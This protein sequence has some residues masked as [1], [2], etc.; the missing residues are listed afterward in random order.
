MGSEVRESL[1]AACQKFMEPIARFLIKHGIGYKEFADVAKIAFV[2]V[3][4]EEYGKRGRPTNISRTSV[5]TGL[6]RK[7]VKRVRTQLEAG[8][9]MATPRLGKPA[10]LLEIWHHDE[11]FLDDKGRPRDLA[12]EGDLGFRGLARRAGG[13]VP[14]G[15]LLT[16]LLNAKAVQKVS[17]DSVRCMTRHFNPAGI[18]PYF[19]QRYGEVLRDLLNTLEVNSASLADEEKLFE[20]RVW[21]DNLDRRYV[22]KFHQLVRDHGTNLLEFL[23]DWLNTHSINRSHDKSENSKRCGMGIYFFTDN[24]KKRKGT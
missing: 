16:E 19:A 14:P 2:N 3:A 18:D 11:Q 4:T 12:L 20:R 7:E 17:E 10:Q 8:H 23:D 1:L 22:N 24:G 5:L 15:A 13:D 9:R 21:H 6:T